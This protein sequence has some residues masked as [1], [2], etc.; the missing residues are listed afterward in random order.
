MQALTDESV[1]EWFDWAGGSA[2]ACLRKNKTDGES[3]L[4]KW[5]QEA[6]D[7]MSAGQS[8]EDLLVR[9]WARR[10]QAIKAGMLTRS[11]LCC[12]SIDE[13]WVGTWLY[14]ELCLETGA[15]QC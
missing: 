3:G 5:I 10:L 8:T 11:C 4:R 14:G 1:R 12:D 13:G 7:V 2:R 6:S 9:P 15:G